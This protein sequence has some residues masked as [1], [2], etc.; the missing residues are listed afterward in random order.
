MY[1]NKERALDPTIRIVMSPSI[2]KV[3]SSR[4]LEH[5]ATLIKKVVLGKESLDIFN[6]KWFC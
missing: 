4:G 2:Q 3:L 6:Q 1:S 5:K